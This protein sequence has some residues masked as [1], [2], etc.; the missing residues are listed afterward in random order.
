MFSVSN[1]IPN[2]PRACCFQY[3]YTKLFSGE[4]QGRRALGWIAAVER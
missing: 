1:R 2:D 4:L 3:R